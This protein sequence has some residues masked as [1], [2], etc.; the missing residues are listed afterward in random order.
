[1]TGS[2]TGR[3]SARLHLLG[4]PCLT[5]AEGRDITPKS[6]KAQALLALLALSPRGTR[7]RIWL[8]DKLWSESDEGRASGS[9]RQSVYELKRALKAVD[10]TL[11]ATDRNALC[12]DLDRLWVD[13]RA[14]REGGGRLPAGVDPGADL[15]EGLDIPDEEFE[16]W[17]TLERSAWA[18]LRDEIGSGGPAA[19]KA[20]PPTGPAGPTA[21]PAARRV[22]Q[23]IE[24]GLL[25]GIVHG[26]LRSGAFIGDYIIESVARALRDYHPVQIVD[27]R[28]AGAGGACE[29]R[30]GEPDFLIRTRTLVVGDTASVSFL[31]YE[32]GT[33]SLVLSQSMQTR[34]KDFYE[35]EFA[36]TNQFV[37]QNVDH[38]AKIIGSTRDGPTGIRND[39]S[40]LIGYGVLAGMFDLDPARMQA[41]TEVLDRLNERTENSLFPS[42]SAYASSFALGEN[43]GG[44]D[45]ERR[46]R[47]EALAMSIL[48]DNPF[49]S[50]A[51]ACI[52]HVMGFVL[53][54]HDIAAEIFGRAVELNPM[55]A[56][57]W[58][59]LALHELYC[60]DLGRARAASERAVN[61]GKYSPISYTYETTACMVATLAGDHARAVQLGRCALVKQPRFNAAMRYTLAALGHLDDGGAA[62]TLR[63]D[64]LALDPGF[65]DRET[66]EMRFRLPRR[67]ACD[68]VLEGLARAGL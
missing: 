47:T 64:L 2:E 23:G 6:R 39:Y 67:E 38:L 65:A 26:G 46:E 15:L 1:M 54:R 44:W 18:R 42:L 35:D 22:P 48:Q 24:I 41:T 40:A 14:I 3:G 45:P 32:N 62:E 10:D 25:P 34:Q 58:D 31:V 51:L 16:D 28:E 43:I 8:R 63:A 7:T 50:I 59:H 52:G 12:L 37:A 30:Q 19:R 60:G 21:A 68:H 56:F 27:L 55:Q 9:L 61:L 33:N 36:L 53:D 20:E 49:N 4:A 11:L 5:D 17:L 66:R 13:L 29:P 57:V